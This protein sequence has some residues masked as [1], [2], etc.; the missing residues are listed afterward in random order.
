[1]EGAFKVVFKDLITNSLKDA[2]FTS[3]YLYIY[4][5]LYVWKTMLL[6]NFRLTIV[7]KLSHDNQNH[8]HQALSLTAFKQMPHSCLVTQL[9]LTPVSSVLLIKCL[10]VMSFKHFKIFLYRVY[11]HPSL[12]RR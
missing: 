8:P 1:M 2:P 12:S 6:T 11:K 5:V 9:I 10:F 7:H 3:V 4:K